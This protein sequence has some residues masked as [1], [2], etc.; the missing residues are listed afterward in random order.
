MHILMQPEL[1][2]ELEDQEEP[3][4]EVLEPMMHGTFFKKTVAMEYA[5]VCTSTSSGPSWTC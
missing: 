4:E 5:T 3:E 2:E 1:L